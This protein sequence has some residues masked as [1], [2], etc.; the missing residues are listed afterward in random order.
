[1][2]ANCRLFSNVITYRTGF[3]YRGV[4]ED[5][6]EARFSSKSFLRGCSLIVASR[7]SRISPGSLIVQLLEQFGN[8]SNLELLLSSRA[9]VLDGR[10]FIKHDESETIVEYSG[11]ILEARRI[12]SRSRSIL[13]YSMSDQC[14]TVPLEAATRVRASSSSFGRILCCAFFY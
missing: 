8:L 9:Y 2:P 4:L 7:L 12:T 11:S 5:L 13:Q 1:M 3:R 6:F 14:R 10:T